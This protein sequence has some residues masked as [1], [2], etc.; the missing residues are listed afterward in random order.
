MPRS[1][2]HGGLQRI[3]VGAANAVELIDA[4]VVRELR[5]KLAE[6]VYVQHDR[7]LTA[8]AAHIAHLPH[9]HPITK[10]LLDVEVVV[11]EVRSPEVLADGENVENGTPAIRVGGHIAGHAGRNTGIEVGVGLPSS[12][13]ER[14][15]R[16]RRGAS[17]VVFQSVGRVGRTEV[18]EWVHV[19]LVIEDTDSA[20]HDQ[21]LSARRLIGEAKPWS[22]IVL[23]GREDGADA[24]ALNLNSTG[25]RNKDRKILVSAVQGAKVVPAE[26][27]VEVE[28]AR[29]LPGILGE[30][31]ETIYYDLAF[32][33]AHGDTG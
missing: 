18:E 26:A 31:V 13:P 27:P 30:E 7:K 17:R 25:G 28:S 16:N 24:I 32:G 9:C 33:V 23:V 20:A 1:Q 29:E 12:R 11:K 5:G 15:G 4:A 22:K 3:I 19:D 2:P 14:V 21:V 6:L 8:F 10:A